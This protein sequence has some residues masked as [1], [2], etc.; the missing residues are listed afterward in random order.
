MH[1][2]YT[3]GFQICFARPPIAADM[4]QQSALWCQGHGVGPINNSD[5]LH[6]LERAEAS[7]TENLTESVVTGG[8]K[9]PITKFRWKACESNDN[10]Q[11]V[12]H[13]L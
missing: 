9:P 7:H 13:M 11:A 6:I 10:R 5:L 8:D 1:L 12:G 2:A 3:S 4:H